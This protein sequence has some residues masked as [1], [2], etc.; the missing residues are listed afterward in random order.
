[1]GLLSRSS[2]AF[3]LCGVFLRAQAP[4]P[5]LRNLD[6][7]H[8]STSFHWRLASQR[9]TDW[10]AR[11]IVLRRQILSSAGLWPLTDRGP[12]TWS[13]QK[14]IHAGNY[15]IETLLIQTLP[16]FYVGANLYLPTSPRPARGRPAVLV[17]HGHWKHGRIEHREDYS[18]PALCANLAAQGY[19]ALAYDMIGYNDTRQ[20]EHS[21]HDSREYRDWSFGP[22]SLQLWDSL[23]AMDLLASHPEVDPARIAVTGASGGGTQTILLAAVDDRVRVSIPAVMVSATFQGDDRCEMHPGLRVG[24]NNVEIAAM[25]APKPMLLISSR[26]DWT[27]LTPGVELPAIRRVYEL[28][29]QA[30]AVQDAHIDAEH[31]Y[32]RQS[33]EAAYRFLAEHLGHQPETGGVTETE[34]FTL[35]PETLLAGGKARRDERAVFESWRRMIL[36]RTAIL[37][38]PWQRRR[39][40]MAAGIEWP[41]TI[42]AL[43]SGDRVL[44]QRPDRG[45][46][47]PA[48]WRE[49]IGSGKATLI[50]HAGGSN[51]AWKLQST[52]DAFAAGDALLALDVFQRGAAVAR[53]APPRGDHLT[54]HRSDDSNRVQDVLTGIAFLA[55]DGAKSVRMVCPGDAALWCVMASVVSPV[56]VTFTPDDR[57]PLGKLAIPGIEAAGGVRLAFSLNSAPR[58]R[59]STP[60]LPLLSWIPVAFGTGAW[61]AEDAN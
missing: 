57:L 45:E 6:H 27:R 38:R 53:R 43:T 54:Y 47:L 15:R 46:Q 10:E 58:R 5:D 22:L 44:L 7:S 40:A 31:N 59:T 3:V 14:S 13:R 1:M 41:R 20:I 56:P 51:A 23:R 60:Q 34:E 29:G 9:L 17:P 11:R 36:A 2:V 49:G 35:P 39:L 19:V 52:D 16:G 37:A 26:R 21:F 33:R 25:M 8:T 4:I 18:V 30:A 32:N 48:L 55:A 50:V 28:Y 24:T 12:V 61:A 42:V